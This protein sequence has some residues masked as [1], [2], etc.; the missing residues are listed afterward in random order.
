MVPSITDLWSSREGK[1]LPGGILGILGFR[2]F[3][4]LVIFGD[5]GV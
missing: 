1:V 5:L 2:D 3:G 4:G